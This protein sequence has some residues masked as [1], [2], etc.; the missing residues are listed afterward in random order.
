MKKKIETKSGFKCTI[1]DK[2]L[3]D[4]RTVE[5]IAYL[6]DNPLLLPR[7]IAKILGEDGKEKL[8]KHLENK[9]GRVPVSSLEPEMAEI[10]E[11]LGEEDTKK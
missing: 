1:D 4:M 2:V 5:M 8:Y 3:D 7:L 10:V 9:E 6:D 11:Q